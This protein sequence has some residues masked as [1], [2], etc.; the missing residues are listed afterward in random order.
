MGRVK[1]IL[2]QNAFQLHDG[3]DTQLRQL[4]SDRQRTLGPASMLFYQEPLEIVRGEGAWLFDAKGQRYLDAYNN[5]PVLGHCHPAVVEAVSSQLATL[6]THTR[7][8][9]PKIHRYS[10]DLL[11][12]LGLPDTRVV[13]T[14]S[15]S[16]ANDVALR[17]AQM[18]TGRQG[19]IVSRAA[20]HGNTALT[21]QVSPSAFRQGSL[22]EWVVAVDL[23]VSGMTDEAAG[24]YLLHQI[25]D[26]MVELNERSYG[27]AALLVDTIFSS[28]GVC[29]DPVGLMA[30]AVSFVKAA[31]G[32]LIADEVQPGFGRTG[33]AFWGFQRQGVVPDIVTMGKPMG[34]GYPVAAVVASDALFSV[35]TSRF[36]YFNTFGGSS[37]A[38]AAAQAVLD[39]L[40]G[41]GLQQQAKDNGALLKQR[42]MAL[43]S[44]HACI[45]D[46][47]GAGLYLGVDI[48]EPDNGKSPDPERAT[49]LINALKQRGV[50]IGAAGQAG[51]TLKIRPPL[52]FTSEHVNHLIA[53]LSLVLEE[54]SY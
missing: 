30:P 17:L 9:D 2:D 46:I 5:V 49:R 44:D 19:I 21:G 12:T 27:C 53:T 4:V 41:E 6:N 31:G 28:D 25:S 11:A 42:L 10:E 52:C 50:L 43:S 29:S 34:N 36:G 40:L 1:P 22:P 35:M 26:A 20:Y 18:Q 37:A 24:Q 51:N 47:R 32:L 33:D 48:V 15:G 16:E 45:G 7:Y 13:F 14:C 54:M 8:L 3:L 39:T 23:P 38:I